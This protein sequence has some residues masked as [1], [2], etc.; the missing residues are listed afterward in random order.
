MTEVMFHVN[1]PDRLAYACRLLRKANAAGAKVVVSGPPPAL[2]KLDALLWA[3]EPAAFVPHLRVAAG[4]EVAARLRETPV[5][6]VDRVEQA[7]HHEVL[8]NLGDELV[9]GF[10]SFDKVIELVPVDDEPKQ[11]AR[12]RWKHYAQRGYPLG[13]HEVAA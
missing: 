13:R 2:A 4:A 10:E 8:V 3:F 5:W 6:L 11:A 12:L 1:V 7:P 9:P